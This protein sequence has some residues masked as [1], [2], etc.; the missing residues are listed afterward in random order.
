[1]KTPYKQITVLIAKA[2]LNTRE[3]KVELKAILRSPF[4]TT[5]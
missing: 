4:F 1:M 3:M 2:I 5:V